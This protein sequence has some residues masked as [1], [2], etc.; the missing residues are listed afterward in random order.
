MQAHCQSTKFLNSVLACGFIKLPNE[1]VLIQAAIVQ[2]FALGTSY[3]PCQTL[4][5]GGSAVVNAIAE[6]RL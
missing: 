3:F 5:S 6:S 4:G 2:G 1:A